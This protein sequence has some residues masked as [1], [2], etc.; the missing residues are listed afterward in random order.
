MQ[1]RAPLRATHAHAELLALRARFILFTVLITATP[2]QACPHPWPLALRAHWYRRLPCS[3]AASALPTVLA[4]SAWLSVLVL[5]HC[6]DLVVA[7][8]SACSSG[9]SSGLYPRRSVAPRSLFALKWLL[10]LV[11]SYCRR[12]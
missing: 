5:C 4:L 1:A 10:H 9:L 3:V 8:L 11:V 6:S 7:G 2:L 12:L